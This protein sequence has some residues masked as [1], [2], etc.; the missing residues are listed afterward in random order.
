MEDKI[1]EFTP[2]ICA[3][4]IP[5]D[6]QEQDGGLMLRTQSAS[7]AL[8]YFFQWKPCR[9]HEAPTRA[10]LKLAEELPGGRI[11]QKGV[12]LE[13]LQEQQG[14]WPRWKLVC[15]KC[16]RTR[17]FL[18]FVDFQWQCPA[19]AHLLYEAQMR[20]VRLDPDYYA[21]KGRELL[22]THGI[23]YPPNM[24]NGDFC[25]FRPEKPRNMQR[26]KFEDIVRQLR[27][28][29]GACNDAILIVGALICEATARKGVD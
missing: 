23:R 14:F 10:R 11:L 1:I 7:K 12:E 27:L 21:R 13:M 9:L 25:I 29:Q 5:L 6:P 22:D 26:R 28:L 20:D 3:D 16:G 19:C 17:R 2:R 15:P 8:L 18:Y 24:S 4:D